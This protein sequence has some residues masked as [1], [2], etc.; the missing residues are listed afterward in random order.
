MKMLWGRTEGGQEKEVNLRSVS[1][2]QQMHSVCGQL[3]SLSCEHSTF[4]ET[5]EDTAVPVFL[6]RIRETQPLLPTET[7]EQR[8]HLC[9]TLLLN[10]WAALPPRQDKLF[11]SAYRRFF[12]LNKLYLSPA[13]GAL[14]LR[15]QALEDPQL[16]VVRS[17]HRWCTVLHGNALGCASNALLC[18]FDPVCP[19]FLNLLALLD[20]LSADLSAIVEQVMKLLFALPVEFPQMCVCLVKHSL[21]SAAHCFGVENMVERQLLYRND[22][23]SAEIKVKGLRCL[24]ERA[25]PDFKRYLLDAMVMESQV[26]PWA[27]DARAQERQLLLVSFV[28]DMCLGTASEALFGS[29]ATLFSS[30]SLAGRVGAVSPLCLQWAASIIVKMTSLPFVDAYLSHCVEDVPIGLSRLRHQCQALWQVLGIAFEKFCREDAVALG[31]A[32]A[33]RVCV[34]TLCDLRVHVEASLRS[35]EK[36]LAKKQKECADSTADV[37]RAVQ[38]VKQEWETVSERLEQNTVVKTHAATTMDLLRLST[39]VERNIFLITCPQRFYPTV[40]RLLAQLFAIFYVT[41]DECVA[42]HAVKCVGWLGMYRLDSADSSFLANL[43]ITYL[44]KA[45]SDDKLRGSPGSSH[46]N[47]GPSPAVS[48]DA[49]PAQQL[50]PNSVGK[51]RLLDLLLFWCDHDTDSLTLRKIEDSLKA[52]RGRSM[53]YFLSQQCLATAD[54]LLQVASLYC[55]GQYTV[56]TFPRVTMDLVVQLARD[57]FRLSSFEMAKAAA[58]SMLAQVAALFCTKVS[59]DALLLDPC[60]AQLKQV[61]EAMRNYQSPPNK[62]LAEEVVPIVH[63]D[64]VVRLHGR[65]IEKLL[66]NFSVSVLVQQ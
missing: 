26:S 57:V 35:L 60:F 16:E 8:L 20:K 53:Y 13:F 14:S 5:A 29:D 22:V 37:D 7:L 10:E 65:T 3:V 43:I 32:D 30:L 39:S 62:V 11:P 63:D 56:A 34:G 61:G 46:A 59:P 6:R 23:C 47:R 40:Q 55:I 12:L 21:T 66:Q 45:E 52:Q 48:R 1:V 33:A 27:A 38:A 50:L 4:G 17:L 58:A 49:R 42:A 28:E 31:T 19:G 44:V 15:R 2:E 24:C 54:P 25:P 36:A 18:I 51:A 41:N 9:I 64:E